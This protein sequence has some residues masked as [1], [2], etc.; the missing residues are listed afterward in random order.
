MKIE[1][2]DDKQT[3]IDYIHTAKTEYISS[4]RRNAVYKV[5]DETMGNYK[6]LSYMTREE[7]ATLLPDY[8][9][10]FEE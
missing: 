7:L 4:H 10:G 3:L 2:Y 8:D 1:N 5:T 6:L 9:F